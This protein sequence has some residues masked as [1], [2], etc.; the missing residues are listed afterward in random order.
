MSIFIVIRNP[1][2]ASNTSLGNRIAKR[3]PK[4]Y[5]LAKGQWLISTDLATPEELG[6]Q[7]KVEE[8][9]GYKGTLILKVSDY[10]G[11]HNQ[12]LWTWLSEHSEDEE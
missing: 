3:F 6:A 2:E 11:L 8:G 4:Y 12:K 5:A 9:S 10:Y 1:T 7:L